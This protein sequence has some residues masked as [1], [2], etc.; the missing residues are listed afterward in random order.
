MDDTFSLSHA[1]AGDFTPFLNTTFTIALDD[2]QSVE[3]V[4]AD[5]SAA[6]GGMVGKREPFSLTFSGT[7]GLVLPQRIYQFSH[8]KINAI[9]IFIVPIASTPQATTYEAIFS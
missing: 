6:T 2:G 1:T 9:E 3:V 7:P 4:L 8:P 5:V